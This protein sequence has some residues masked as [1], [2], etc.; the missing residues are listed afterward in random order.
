[1]AVV[2]MKKITIT[3]MISQRSTI[4]DVL[5]RLETLHIE[6]IPGAEDASAVFS[7]GKT[8]ENQQRLTNCKKDIES[9]SRALEI[10]DS[11]A[12]VKTSML[13]GFAGRDRL[14]VSDFSEK[15]KKNADTLKAAED[16][17]ELEKE[18]ITVKAAVPK[19][20]NERASLGP[21]LNFKVPLTFKGTGC[22]AAFI[23]SFPELITEENLTK[24]LVGET[25]IEAVNVDV[26]SS[27]DDLTCLMVVCHKDDASSFDEALRK[28]NF[29]RA[30]QIDDLPLKKDEE[31]VKAIEKAYKDTDSIRVKIASYSDRRED[32]KFTIDSLS[33]EYERLSADEQILRSRRTFIVDGYVPSSQVERTEKALE[34]Y[35]VVIEV[36]DPTAKDNVPVL[37][38]NNSFAAPVEGVVE[39]YSLP[40]N[41]EMDPS[42]P[43][44]I[45]YYFMFGMMLSD[46][47]YG[48]IMT[49]ATG[50]ILAKFK[51]MEAGMRK[52]MKMFCY[53][54]IGTMVSGILF[55]SYFGDAVT[56]ASRMFFDKDV[57]IKPLYVDP[58]SNSMKVLVFS[59]AIGIIHLFTGLILNLWQACKQK[60]YADAI[61]DSLFWL[62][63]VGGLLLFGLTTD[64]VINM[65]PGALTKIPDPLGQVGKVLAIIGAVGILFTGG[66]ESK[67]WVKRLMKGA[68]ALYNVTGYL[69]DIL[70]YSRLLALGLATS[71]ISTVFNSMGEMVSAGLLHTN[72]FGALIGVILFLVIFVIG[73]GLNFAINALG[74]YVHANR[75]QF[76]EF[77]GKFYNGGGRKFEPLAVK[78]KYFKFKED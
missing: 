25:G 41:G 70:S 23:G 13:A 1:M 34:P 24:E 4:L 7:T 39:S 51:N 27:A 8:E 17:L 42:M 68:Y 35:D 67:N 11:Y 16:I 14:S 15:E 65:F 18:L 46:F 50:A 44:A 69:S 72:I 53:C 6:D 21:W 32:L 33:L 38:K 28:M 49:V 40:S 66:R 76:V 77:F 62:F 26:I 31:L 10:L 57:V 52:T 61:Y 20:E 55:G 60:R 45:F 19:Y 54:G 37:L 5:Q 71:V 64:M 30:P 73:H 22:T 3:G 12:P 78:T 43:V 75:L 29:S 36:Q 74:A 9:L 56:V 47:A 63:L 48:L 58:I 59:F 2:P